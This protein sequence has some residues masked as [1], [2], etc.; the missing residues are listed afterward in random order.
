M[1]HTEELIGLEDEG[2]KALSGGGSQA[3]GFYERVLDSDVAMLLPGGLVLTDRGQILDSMSGAPWSTY[4]MEDPQVLR[5]TDD[6]GVV[7]YRVKAGRTGSPDYR[8][9][10]SSTYVRRAS[11]WKLAF[12]QQTPV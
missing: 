7:I 2:W 3:A 6:T 5:P 1:G 11:G 4:R 9:L 10:I 12:H 8:A